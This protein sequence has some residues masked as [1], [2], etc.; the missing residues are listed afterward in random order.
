MP[1]FNF[2]QTMTATMSFSKPSLTEIDLTY[3]YHI[4]WTGEDYEVTVYE[5]EPVDH[6]SIQ[7][8]DRATR[9]TIASCLSFVKHVLTRDMLRAA[10]DMVVI[11]E[12]I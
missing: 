4:L 2:A 10:Q 7:F 12:Q 1:D 8:I 6:A 9:P 11:E 3:G 5:D